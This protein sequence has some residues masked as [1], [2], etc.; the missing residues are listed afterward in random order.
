MAVV[1]LGDTSD[2]RTDATDDLSGN[3]A[4][5]SDEA[6]KGRGAFDV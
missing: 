6:S 2:D 4:V 1:S 3:F 5:R